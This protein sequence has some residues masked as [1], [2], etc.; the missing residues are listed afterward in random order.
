[1][2]RRDFI[3][4]VGGAAVAWP[5]AAHAQQSLP[6][7]GW[8]LGISA[9]ASQPTLAA[10]RKA[11]GAEGYVEGQNVQ[12]DYRWADGHY[13]RL[14]TMASELVARPVVL[15]VTGG[16]DPPALAAKAATSTIPIVMV[17]GSDPVK[18][19]LVA[20][21]NHPGGNLTGASIFS[22]E[23]ESK[24]LGLLHEAVPA[25]KIIAALF[26]PANPN[27]D[28]QR[29][30]AQDS[31]Q[32]LG[33]EVLP[34]EANTEGTITAAFADMA[35]RKADGVM[36]TADPVYNNNRALLIALAAQYRLPAIYEFRQFV[37]DG[38]MMSYGTV[39]TDAYS[40]AG[41]YAGRILKG[42][43][44]GDLPVVLPTNFQFAI[45]LKTAKS[46]GIEFPPT[47]SARADEV[48]E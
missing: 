6:V 18:A 37:V 31:A 12:I 23:M 30:D 28:V 35:E 25:A 46:L 38:G 39:L 10:F 44:P 42:E 4:L 11:L 34:F 8:L 43:K 41:T 14:P 13:D 27:V 21:L 1:M 36:V 17:T 24:R 48:I 32:H 3:T 33:V 16:G 47:L 20:S 45:N 29:R 19:G 2:R 22:Y 5:L 26:N 15:I 9:A 7:I 40:Q